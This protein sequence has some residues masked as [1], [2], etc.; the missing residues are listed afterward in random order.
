[1]L[2]GEGQER[3]N[4]QLLLEKYA[5]EKN[6]HLAGQLPHDAVQKMMT[7]S[8]VLIHPSSYEGFPGVCL[9]A[10]SNGAKVISFVKPMND[11]IMSWKI[12]TSM[13]EMIFETGKLLNDPDCQVSP[14][15]YPSMEEVAKRMVDLFQQS[16]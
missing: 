11:D 9:E 5:L 15:V 8:K 16:G 6:L 2:I 3:K 10:L 12:V 4:I 14:F 13:E 7:R 1:M